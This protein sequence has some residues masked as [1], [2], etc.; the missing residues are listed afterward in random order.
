MNIPI[1]SARL[2]IHAQRL[3]KS[4]DCLLISCNA[5]GMLP[6][7]SSPSKDSRG[8]PRWMPSP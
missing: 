4:Q 7:T 3:R 5:E 2:T 8:L 6:I 1:T